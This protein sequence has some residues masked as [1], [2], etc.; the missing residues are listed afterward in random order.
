ME[1]LLIINPLSIKRTKERIE[2]VLHAIAGQGGKDG[3]PWDHIQEAADYI[4]RLKECLKPV[5]SVYEKFKHLDA[6]LS[7]ASVLEDDSSPP[8]KCLYELWKAIKA[9]EGKNQDGV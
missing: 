2:V 5:A 9:A 8:R 1:D 7:D 4:D 3:Y 6:I